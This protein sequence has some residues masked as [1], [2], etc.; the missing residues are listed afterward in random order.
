M[1]E[2]WIESH[3]TVKVQIP[4][5]PNFLRAEMP[6]AKEAMLPLSAFSDKELRDIAGKWADSLIERAVEQ[7]KSKEVLSR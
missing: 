7:R 4:K 2:K 3:R 6:G 5:P 1:E